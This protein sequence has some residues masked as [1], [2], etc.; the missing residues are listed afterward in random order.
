[1]PH[2]IYVNVSIHLPFALKR[3]VFANWQI[4]WQAC[5]YGNMRRSIKLQ[6]VFKSTTGNI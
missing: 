1:M 5:I 2:S 4:E 3:V 6:F